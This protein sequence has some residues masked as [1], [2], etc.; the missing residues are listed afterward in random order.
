MARRIVQMT[1]VHPAFD[2]RIYHKECRSLALA[3]YDVTLIAPYE[4]DELVR[5]GFRLRGVAPPRKRR[6]RL[7]R[8][9]NS[10]YRAAVD[11]DAE[12]YHFHDPELM[13]IGMLL[14]LRGKKVVYDVHE[15]Y[16][17]N[18][19]KQWI[20]PT[21]RGPASLAVRIS[22]ATIARVCDHVVA[23]TPKIAS[24]FATRRTSVVQNFP[25]IAEFDSQQGEPYTRREAIVA[26]VG[27]LANARGLQ[28]M[29]E[30]MRLVNGEVPARLLMAGRMMQG[31]QAEGFGGASHVEV[32]GE[33]GRMQVAQLL[34]R[35]RIGIVVYHPTPNYY[36]GQPTK[37]L[38]YMAAGLPVVASDFPFYREVIQSSGCGILVDPLQPR[39]IADAM[40]WLLR[41]EGSA[42]EMG[43]RGRQAV[44]ERFNWENE[45]RR[46]ISTY[47]KL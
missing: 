45:A 38:E 28:E 24:Q 19:Q 40:L 14:K 11:E 46:L 30:A 34:S 23:A 9:I 41:N 43:K 15:D 21:L 33:S 39:Q 6:E 27:Y 7:T 8:T 3:G 17:S 47:D 31:A 5:D 35:A 1:S 20:P 42:E 32:L 18:M 2:T 10:V 29:A 16:A 37:L 22:E 13:P 36:Y 44:M 12:I 25:R 26:Y 4:G